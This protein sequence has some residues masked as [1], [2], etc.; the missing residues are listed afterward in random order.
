MEGEGEPE[1]KRLA[2]DP[3]G[4][5]QYTL[6]ER[7]KAAKAL[8]EF[9]HDRV[10]KEVDKAI[11]DLPGLVSAMLDVVPGASGVI[12]DA[13]ELLSSVVADQLCNTFAFDAVSDLGSTW[14]N[15]GIGVAVSPDDT[16]LRW[17]VRADPT[18]AP[19]AI[20]PAKINVY[21]HATPVVIPE[22]GWRITPIYRIREV[23]GKASVSGAVVRREVSN[24]PAKPVIG[25]TVRLGCEQRLTA[26]ANR[27]IGFQFVD[28]K[29]GR[30]HL[31]ASQFVLDPTTNIWLEWKSKRE[32]IKLLNGDNISGVVL[33]LF[34]R[35]GWPGRSTSCPTTISS[36]AWSSER[37]GGV[38]RT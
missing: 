13:K 2:A 17:D 12:D 33:E 23:I 20:S 1:D 21:G 15:P 3:D 28:T 32:D 19:P 37:T 35:R 25:A 34:P 10:A 27:T 6:P 22:P 38:T 4:L 26:F 36:I 8:F 11:D 24:Q 29:A 9:T 16:K 7:T 30:Y 18:M 31:Q 14:N 5:Y